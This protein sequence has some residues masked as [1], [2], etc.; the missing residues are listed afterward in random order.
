MAPGPPV[1]HVCPRP[2]VTFQGYVAPVSPELTTGLV[3]GSDE[4]GTSKSEIRDHF[5][6][7]SRQQIF[8]SMV[9][10]QRQT[11]TTYNNDLLTFKQNKNPA[12]IQEGK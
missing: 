4:W 10:K 3:L 1:A 5:K 9:V 7:K 12:G 6:C 8:Y 11:Y 2:R